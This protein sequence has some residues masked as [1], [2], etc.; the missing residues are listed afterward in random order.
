MDRIL[1]AENKSPDDYK[2]SKQADL[3]MIFFNLE[4][5][6]VTALVETLGYTLPKDYLKRNLDY[7]LARTSHGSTLSRV[8][9][10]HL[11]YKTG[12][13]SMG[14]KLFMEALQSDL[15]D[16]QGGTT[17]EGIHCGVMAGTVYSVLKT[18][19]GLDLS[20]GLPEICPDLPASWNSVHFSFR[21]KETKYPV[22]LSRDKVEISAQKDGDEKINIHLCGEKYELQSNQKLVIRMTI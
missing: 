2:V 15:V 16:I 4:E 17:G 19:C 1:K 14:W 21:F 12:D 5:R 20:E 11:A 9:H 8:V 3:L 6:E 18:F 7:Y 13:R 10:A 22:D